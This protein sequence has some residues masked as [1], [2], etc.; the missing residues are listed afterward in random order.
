[1]AAM[2]MRMN[3]RDGTSQYSGDAVNQTK[4]NL[5]KTTGAAPALSDQDLQ[6]AFAAAVAALNPDC[7]A[8][9]WDAQK[10]RGATFLE[11][12]VAGVGLAEALLLMA[13]L[14]V[15]RGEPA[16]QDEDWE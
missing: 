3:G 7:A 10:I 16:E 6:Q 2:R 8:A 5:D 4:D 14:R 1:M 15:W 11:L 12:R 9:A 13:K